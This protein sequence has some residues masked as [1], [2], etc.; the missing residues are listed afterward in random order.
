M[1]VIE[2]I[3]KVV[4][5]ND[6]RCVVQIEQMSACA[7]CQVKSACT[8]SEKEEKLIEVFFVDEHIEVGEQ[9]LLVG[10]QSL[11]L[12]AVF[13]AYV[14]PL[15]VICLILVLLTILN[16]NETLAGTI[17]LCSILPYYG[18]LH[19][20]KDRFKRN[21]AFKLIKINT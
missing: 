1:S 11:G 8:V 3:G 12:K 6:T 2:H 17:A 4:E 18:I 5:V 9:V 20:F 7:T 16:V 19:F 21:F 10:Q 13:F 14:L 15:L